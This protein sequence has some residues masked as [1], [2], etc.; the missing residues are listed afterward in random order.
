MKVRRRKALVMAKPDWRRRM[1]VRENVRR[2]RSIFTK[3]QRER[4]VALAQLG[5]PILQIPIRYR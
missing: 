5:P 4:A 1:I 2:F 3:Q